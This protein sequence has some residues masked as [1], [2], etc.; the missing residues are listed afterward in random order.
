MR[1]EPG[2]TLKEIAHLIGCAFVGD[3][4]H[5]I[6]GINEIH[7]V[8]P[9]DIVFVDHPKYY[10][11]ALQSAAT[12]I[13]INK[14]VECPKGKALLLSDD[15]FRDFNKIT[16][17]YSPI[18]TQ[19]LAVCHDTQI[20]DSAVIYPNVVIGHNVRIGERSIIHPGVVIYDNAVI[21]NDVIIHANAVIG[22]HAFYYKKRPEGFDKMH[23]CG[24]VVIHDRVEIGAATT[25]DSGVTGDT[26]IGEGTKIDNHVHI[27]HDTVVGKDCLFA[28]QVGIAGCVV[29]EDRVTLW[30]QVGIPSGIHIGTGAV[31]LGQSGL[32][33]N[34]EAGKTYFG[35]PA[36]EHKSK[37]RELAALRH[38]PELM[39]KL[40]S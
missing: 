12:T 11:K 7:K 23:T 18:T 2:T 40:K 28:A 30:G 8:V 27:G 14:E 13:I 39:A 15:P 24:R 16:R 19:H 21:G 3:E 37:Y 4:K 31:C 35:S 26:V 10:D 17:H 1:I 33:S 38:L 5:P 32:M 9:G 22:A 36:G 6:T 25:I 20:H 29:I 34:A